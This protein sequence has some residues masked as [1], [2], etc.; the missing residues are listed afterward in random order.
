M[1]NVLLFRSSSVSRVNPFSS[2]HGLSLKLH[3]FFKGAPT[4]AQWS[5]VSDF[6]SIWHERVVLLVALSVF[7]GFYMDF[8]WVYPSVAIFPRFASLTCTH[9]HT[10]RC[11]KIPGLSISIFVHAAWPAMVP[12]SALCTG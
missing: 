10:S 1:S 8:H 5:A 7:A 6:Q 4:Y 3:L 9:Y 11:R 12:L 2:Q